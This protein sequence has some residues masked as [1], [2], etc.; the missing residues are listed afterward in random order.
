VQPTLSTQ[1]FFFFFFFKGPQ[2]PP[3]KAV[4]SELSRVRSGSEASPLEKR[5][6]KEKEKE[7][8]SKNKAKKL[9]NRMSVEA[10]YKN[11]LVVLEAATYDP[12]RVHCTLCRNDFQAKRDT[13]IDHLK[14][15]KH[16][17]LALPSTAV[18][19][20]GQQTVASMF[21]FKEE[22]VNPALMHRCRVVKVFLQSGISVDKIEGELKN[23]LE[24][25]RPQALSLGHYSNL[26]RDHLPSLVLD[27]S[28]WLASVLKGKKLCLIADASPRF[29]EGFVVVTRWIEHDFSIRQEILDFKLFDSPLKGLDYVHCVLEAIDSAQIKRVN[30]ATGATDRAATN[31]VLASNLISFIPKYQHSW[32][33]A[34]VFDGL[35]KQLACPTLM[36]FLKCWSKVFSKSPG[37]RDIFHSL[38]KEAWTRKHRIRW[39]SAYDQVL[40]VQRFWPQLGVLVANLK[41]AKVAEEGTKK[42]AL[43]LADQTTT[44]CDLALELN[45]YADVVRR[46]REAN[47]LLQGDG[48]LAPFVNETL[49]KVLEM[50]NGIA[51]HRLVQTL[52]NVAVCIMNAPE[53]VNRPALWSKVKQMIN[54]AYS[55]FRAIFLD[56]ALDG[57]AKVSFAK[58]KVLFR[59]AQLFHPH[60]AVKWMNRPGDQTLVI[61]TQFKVPEVVEILGSELITR[62]ESE[63]RSLVEEYGS[64]LSNGP[65]FLN[66]AELREF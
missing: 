29:A 38:A 25:A 44:Y 52:P 21:G 32:C 1:V 3:L 62:M 22:A 10:E 6:K 34:H 42:L 41:L 4:R 36:L 9:L 20:S 60:V 47:L 14:R 26:V 49:G 55:K 12:D 15:K 8:K 17:R 61:S 45:M 2:P 56:V 64:F 53:H 35:G 57:E 40:Q 58:P 51:D 66:P 46:F 54:P 59:F 65:P 27:H 23:L 16:V 28:E 39:G 5:A 19:P 43:L 31:G 50:F 33:L 7:G 11:A 37:A 13:L 48:F 30:V 63:W 18:S 24:E